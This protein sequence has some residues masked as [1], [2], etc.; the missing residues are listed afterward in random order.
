VQVIAKLRIQGI[1]S[2]SMAAVRHQLFEMGHFG[3]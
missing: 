2:M 3:F 1:Q